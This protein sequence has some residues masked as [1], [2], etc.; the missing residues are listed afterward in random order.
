MNYIKIQEFTFKTE[1][2]VML[3]SDDL[4]TFYNFVIDKLIN[5]AGDS[6]RKG[7]GQSLNEIRFFEL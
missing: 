7:P 5:E 1:N 6:E 3:R 4:N 2:K